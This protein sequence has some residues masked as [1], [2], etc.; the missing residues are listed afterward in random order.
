MLAPREGHVGLCVIPTRLHVQGELP[1]A[2]CTQ[3]G[4]LLGLNCFFLMV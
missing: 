4:I 3:M 1:K 2:P